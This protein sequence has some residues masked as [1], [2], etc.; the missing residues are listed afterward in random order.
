MISTEFKY[1]LDRGSRKFP[2]PVCERKRFVR[3]VD[4]ET[5]DYLSPEYGRCDRENN[6]GYHE[7]P[8]EAGLTSTRPRHLKPEQPKPLK[9]T[10]LP[11]EY[12]ERSEGN[13][14]RNTLIA[15]MATLPGWSTKMAEE[16]ARRYRVGTTDEGWAIFWQIDEQDKLRSGKMI[17]YGED[18]RRQKEGYSYDWVHSML[19][20]KGYLDDFHLV[21][22]FYGLHLVDESK[23]VAIVES[24]KTAIIA[25]QYLPQF[26]WIASGQLQGINE[27][28][29]QPLAGRR[30]ILFPDC[31]AFDQWQ[32]YADEFRDI[33]DFTVS[34]LLEQK[35]DKS[36]GYDLA[37]YLIQFQPGDFWN[38]NTGEIFDERRYP[39]DWDEI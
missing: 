18:G 36:K 22:C 20:R 24:E 5:G 17:R 2:C 9:P 1:S 39:K 25:S 15:W 29:L 33:A 21:Q 26:H 3:Y 12:V 6:C 38:P 35:G 30:I 23:L 34:G 31:G 13:Y 7:P 8:R 32:A 16:A 10:T 28:K 11:I 37:D 19:K 27:Y 4:N 14:G